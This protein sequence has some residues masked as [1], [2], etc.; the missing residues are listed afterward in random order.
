MKRRAPRLPH[1]CCP[2]C[3]SQAFARTAGKTDS[4]YRELYYYCRQDL[5]CGHV[6][7]V[8]MQ[9]LR[10]IRPAARPNPEV[11]LP[12]IRYGAEV[13]NDRTPAPANDDHLSPLPPVASAG[14]SEPG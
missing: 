4:T 14:L 8:G 3:G 12:I 7:L 6:F 10:T 2:H 1:I 5:A 11:Y 13:A 9:I